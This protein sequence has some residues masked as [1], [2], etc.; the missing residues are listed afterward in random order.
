[1]LGDR[2]AEGLADLGVFHAVLQRRLRQSAAARGDVDA[3]KLQP[4][5]G[6]LHAVA[7]LAAD[8]VLGPDLVVPEDQF[9]L[10]MPL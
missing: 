1:V 8:Q 2:L 10:S 5:Q 6:G 9:G 4:A 3:A 7:F